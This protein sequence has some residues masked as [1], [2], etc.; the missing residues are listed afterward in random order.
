M[1]I[2]RPTRRG[3]LGFLAAPA[4]VRIASLMPVKTIPA[5]LVMGLDL[6]RGEDM[7]ALVLMETNPSGDGWL[8]RAFQAGRNIG[9][10]TISSTTMWHDF[11]ADL[12][13]NPA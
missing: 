2:I 4:I 7:T 9:K 3:F 10:P 1:S 11:M 8:L 13:R 5:P 6:A 12:D